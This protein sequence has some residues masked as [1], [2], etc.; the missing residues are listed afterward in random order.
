MGYYTI[1]NYELNHYQR[2]ALQTADYPN[3]GKNMVYPALGL[4]GE[5]GETAEKVKKM[6]R[7]LG[8]TDANHL[9]TE[10][11]LAIIKEMGDCLW[12]LAALAE[13]LSVDL[14]FVATENIKKL[15]DRKD[16]GVIKSEGDSR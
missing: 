13:E 6:W 12:Y 4:A 16:R 14:S 2:D 8:V 15:R 1:L 9:N 5:A 10:Q 11:K 7:N 3:K